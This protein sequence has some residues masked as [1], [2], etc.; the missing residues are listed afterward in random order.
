MTATSPK[1]WAFISYSHRDARVARGLQ[2]A[3]ETYRLPGRLVGQATQLGK[4]PAR[5]RPVF[6]D[7]DELQAGTDLKATV[8]DALAQSRF[9][10]VL[11]SP[12]AARSEWVNRE[13]IEFKQQHGGSRVLAVIT[14]GEPFASNQPGRQAE[15]CF[16]PALRRELTA[17]GRADGA[18]LEPI[19]ADLRPHADGKRRATLKLIAGMVGVGADELLQRDARRRIRQLVFIAAASLAGMAAMGVLAVSAVRARN[20]AQLQ[21]GEA[22]ELLQFMLGDLRK[23]LDSVGRLDVLDGVGERALQYYARQEADRLDANSL[24][25]RARALHLIGELREQRGQLDAAQAAFQRA[26][27]STAQLLRRAPRDTQRIFDHA[28]SVY[29][30]GYLSRLRGR[31]PEAERAFREYVRLADLLVQLDGQNLDWQ[32]EAAYARDNVGVVLLETSRPREALEILSQ[33]RDLWQR[34]TVTQS[35]HMLELANTLG[36]IA[37]A[38][39]A[40][41]DYERAISTQLEKG[42][43]LERMPDADSNQQVRR[44]RFT[45]AGELARLELALGR[46]EAARALALDA[47]QKARA[48]VAVD[49]KNKTWLEQRCLAQA[50]LTEALL[51]TGDRAGA[52]Q[53]LAEIR[54]GTARLLALDPQAAKWQVNLRGRMLVLAVQLAGDADRA[55]LVDELT[56]YLRKVSEFTTTDRA[57][58]EARNVIVAQAEL[59]L[60]RLMAQT[61]PPGADRVHWLAV[62]ARLQ[63]PGSNG[64]LV[65]LTTLATAHYLLG[66][67]TEAHTLAQR[68]ESTPF[69]HPAYAELKR[70]LAVGAGPPAVQPQHH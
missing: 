54:E 56:D 28:Q 41:G 23:Q 34:I 50:N 10:I 32:I 46:A 27:E 63:R 39:E 65:A 49:P 6:L 57:L 26:A 33:Q 9:L 1:Y 37:R 29:W 62:V 48:L 68:I 31:M 16:P 67:V 36:W 66:S 2:R 24:G 19:A 7:R 5:L 70:L 14:A 13:I 4:V 17:S 55:A 38:H 58:T 60:G 30:V 53:M 40:G 43:V 45:I 44:S 47:V 35:G 51:A 3:L 11:C 20:E 59:A 8:S 21:R 42:R 64:D 18:P 69:R 25:R 61:G 52:R 15:E 12:D 22:E